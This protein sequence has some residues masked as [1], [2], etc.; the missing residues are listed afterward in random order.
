[1][2]SGGP[3]IS[4]Q[5]LRG[6]QQEEGARLFMVLL[7]GRTQ[8]KRHKLKKETIRL[9]IRN[10]FFTVWTAKLWSRLF[11]GAVPCCLH[12]WRFSRSDWIKT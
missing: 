5:F 12:P 11:R 10:K 7:G 2:A 1:M 8:G 3:S 9:D 6:G 4:P